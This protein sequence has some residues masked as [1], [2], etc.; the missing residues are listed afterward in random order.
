MKLISVIQRR[1]AE[2]FFLPCTLFCK[3][4]S[5][6]SRNPVVWCQHVNSAEYMGSQRTL[7]YLFTSSHLRFVDPADLCGHPHSG[8]WTS[9]VATSFETSFLWHFVLFNR[10][11]HQSWRLIIQGCFYN[12]LR[13]LLFLTGLQHCHHLIHPLIHEPSFMHQNTQY[14]SHWNTCSIWSCQPNTAHS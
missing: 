2:L 11:K 1:L 7:K 5:A 12:E 9:Y 4:F 3:L 8:H 13:L 10:R 6:V 14:R